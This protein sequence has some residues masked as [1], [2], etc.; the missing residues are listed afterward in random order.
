MTPKIK[1]CL[2]AFVVVVFIT[3]VNAQKKWYV[4]LDVGAAKNIQSNDFY[5]SYYIDTYYYDS[6]A[7]SAVYTSNANALGKGSRLGVYIGYRLSKAISIELAINKKGL[8]SFD[9]VNKQRLQA[10][11]SPFF[12]EATFTT[13]FNANGFAITPRICI[14]ENLKKFSPYL[15]AGA[16]LAFVD[17]WSETRTFVFNNIPNWE[18]T[19]SSEF[20]REYETGATLGSAFSG[21]CGYALGYGFGLNAE[22]QWEYLSVW[23][24][25]AKVTSYVEDGVDKLSTLSVSEENI[26][27]VDSFATDENANQNLPFKRVKEMYS[28]S[29][30]NFVVGL[31][32]S[33]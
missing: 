7:S 19:A 22:L 20:K 6:T 5:N 33:F 23:P 27:F 17:L 8:A 26:Q 13:N 11:G 3:N 24:T 28:L 25:S 9:Q 1:N 32:Y 12:Y 14:K 10:D 2:L 29:S 16:I 31:S 21:G 4:G 15:K 18:P 30:L